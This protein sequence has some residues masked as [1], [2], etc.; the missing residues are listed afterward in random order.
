[1]VL[2]VGAG[3]MTRSFVALANV[4][5]GFRPDHL[6]AVNFTISTNRHPDTYAQ[7]Y[8][9]VIDRVR[10]LPGVISAGAAKN[11]PFR[12]SGE[13]NG[14]LPPGMVVGPN[15][16]TPTAI[17]MHISDGLLQT[18]GATMRAGRE[19][20]LQDTH[21]TPFV[22]V[23]N[24]TLARRY[25]PN[26]EAAGKTIRIGTDPVQIVGVVNDIH[27]TSM[28]EPVRPTLYIDNMQNSRVKDHAGGPHPGRAAGD[29][30]ADPRSHLV[31][32]QGP[33]DQQHLHL[34]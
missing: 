2:V 21:G 34:R 16:Q 11:A 24:E 13:N 25:F 18:I 12:G 32:R 23:V 6:V 15:D 28:D 17:F 7:Y 20:T 26:G 10:A 1:M 3:L 29:G 22:V 31:A 9:A 8:H 33:D 5:P 27:Q 19:F 4:D 14:F 30:A